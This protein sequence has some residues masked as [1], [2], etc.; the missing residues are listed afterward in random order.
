MDLTEQ[1]YI[2]I[3]RCISLMKMAQVLNKMSIS[4]PKDH[5]QVW[6]TICE[7]IYIQTRHLPRWKVKVMEARINWYLNHGE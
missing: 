6:E 2:Y 7:R 4:K 3:E 5:V 1:E